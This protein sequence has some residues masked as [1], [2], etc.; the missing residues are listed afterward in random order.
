MA[1]TPVVVVEPQDA[2]I[3]LVPRHGVQGGLRGVHEHDRAVP[4]GGADEG[5]H[6]VDHLCQRVPA[7]AH[8]P[9][10]RQLAV[11]QPAL[12]LAGAGLD[13]ALLAAHAQ[14]VAA[15]ADELGLVDRAAQEVGGARR[16]RLQAE[17]A[18][19]VGG[20]DDHGDVEAARAGAQ[21]SGELGAVQM[22]HLVF[23]DDQVG[24]VAGQ[25]GQGRPWIAEGDHLGIGLERACQPGMDVPVGQAIVEDGDQGHGG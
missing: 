7:V 25:P 20:D 9:R 11:L 22:G 10:A 12:Q 21:A 1:A 3:R 14:E 16:Q 15:A 4:V 2:A 13:D 8:Q 17:R 24:I 19:I 18:V 6:G 5:R 23:G